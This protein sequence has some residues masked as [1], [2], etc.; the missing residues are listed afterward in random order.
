[1]FVD[2]GV[3]VG[4]AVV[5]GGA[6]RGGEEVREELGFVE[7]GERENGED[8]SGRVWGGDTGNGGFGD[9]WREVLDGDVSERDTLD[10]F[11]KLAVGVLVL[12][13][14]L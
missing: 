2:D 6:G 14:G 7:A 11:F 3:L 10:D 5:G 9:G 1:M 8:R 12:V 4:V 13:F